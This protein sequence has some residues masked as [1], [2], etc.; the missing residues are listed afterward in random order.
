MLCMAHED[1]TAYD[2]MA[3]QE[4]Q[5]NQKHTWTLP[6][7]TAQPHVTTAAPDRLLRRLIAGPGCQGKLLQTAAL[8]MNSALRKRKLTERCL[9]D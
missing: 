6:H 8:V 3:T 1:G 7:L 5:S 2:S 4:H 9:L